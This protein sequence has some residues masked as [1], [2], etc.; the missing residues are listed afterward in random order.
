VGWGFGRGV[1]ERRGTFPWRPAERGGTF[2][3]AARET[4]TPVASDAGGLCP[5]RRVRRRASWESAT[6]ILR[7]ILQHTTHLVF[8][9]SRFLHQSNCSSIRVFTICKQAPASGILSFSPPEQ[10]Q[11]TFTVKLKQQHLIKQKLQS[12]Q[13][14]SRCKQKHGPPAPPPPWTRQRTEGTGHETTTE[15][16][17]RRRPRLRR[18][19]VVRCPRTTSR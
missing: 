15:R 4:S 11:L 18:S 9:F 16:K 13:Q 17:T 1:G 12:R 3:R 2:P 10:Q 8:P 5:G 7:A 6:M 14:D 19:C